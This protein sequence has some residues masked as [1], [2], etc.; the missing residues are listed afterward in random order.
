MLRRIFIFFYFAT[1][2]LFKIESKTP[3]CDFANKY[4]L[5]EL[6]SDSEKRNEFLMAAA[7]WEGRFA[8]NGNGLNTKVGVTYDGTQI[9][10]NTGLQHA[11]L[12]DFS[13]ASKE[14]IHLGL[15]ALA[16]DGKNIHNHI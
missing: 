9:D 15:L 4:S 2:L 8:T 14:S 11:P 12:H 10:E 6:I 1:V 13:A 16:L 3:D 7:Y 5:D